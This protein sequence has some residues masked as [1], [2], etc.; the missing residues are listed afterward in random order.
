MIRPA[1]ALDGGSRGREAASRTQAGGRGGRDVGSPGSPAGPASRGPP[2]RPAATHPQQTHFELPQR[3]GPAAWA[4]ARRRPKLRR[5][6]PGPAQAFHGANAARSGCGRGARKGGGRPFAGP[7]SGLSAASRAGPTSAAGTVPRP[8]GRRRRRRHLGTPAGSPD[9]PAHLG[10]HLRSEGGAQLAPRS[11]WA[12]GRGR[13]RGAGP[14]IR[15]PAPSR[16]P[17][18]QAHPKMAGKWARTPGVQGRPLPP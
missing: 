6:R 10:S 17:R 15:C 16:R 2:G 4:R 5:E 3:H 8:P 14:G 9:L 18:L 1:P 13:G 12:L 11:S 7:C